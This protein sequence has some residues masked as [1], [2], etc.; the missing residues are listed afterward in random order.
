MN[1]QQLTED[2]ARY[3]GIPL[4]ADGDFVNGYA[5]QNANE[6]QDG[7]LVRHNFERNGLQLQDSVFMPLVSISDAMAVAAYHWFKIEYK[8]DSVV[9]S[10]K[11]FSVNEP[12]L[13]PTANFKTHAVCRAI[14]K[15]AGMVKQ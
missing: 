14:T 12:Y 13:G 6:I 10:G 11:T 9:V 8:Q 15:A 5:W 7:A 3:V 1:D 4:F 2:C